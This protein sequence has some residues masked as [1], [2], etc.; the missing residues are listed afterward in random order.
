MKPALAALL[1]FLFLVV[2]TNGAY[3]KIN[4]NSNKY[5]ALVIDAENGEVLYSR[6]AD[7]KRYPASLTKMMTIYLLFEAMR[8]GKITPSQKLNVSSHAAT[9]P[10]TNINLKSGDKIA[11][12]DAIKAL[13]VRSANDVAVVA[14]EAIGGSEWRFAQMMT[15][16][17]HQLGMRSTAFR[18]PHGLPDAQQYTTARDL[19]RLAIAL[20]RDF[21]Q[22]YHYFKTSSFTWKGTTYKSHNRALGRI[23]GADGLKTGY[24]NMSGFN[25]ATSVKRDGYNVVGIVL[26]GQTGRDRDD[27][28]VGLMDKSFIQLAERNGKG[29]KGTQ[30]AQAPIPSPKPDTGV[31]MEDTQEVA[32]IGQG[33]RGEAPETTQKPKEQVVALNYGKVDIV[34][35]DKP[36]L[37]APASELSLISDAKADM[38]QPKT[39]IVEEQIVALD[40][41]PAQPKSTGNIVKAAF[42]PA[43]GTLQ[44]QFAMLQ[45]ENSK[46]HVTKFEQHWGIQVGAFA[47]EK[48]A[49]DAAAKAVDLARDQLKNSKVLVSDPGTKESSIHRARIANL[50]ERQAKQA[51]A[52]LT[53]SSKQC[54]VYRA[55][56]QRDL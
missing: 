22:Y 51:C 6:N 8:D 50:S 14:A 3:A 52:K 33:D 40:D 15:A 38:P 36:S 17:A 12:D 41:K 13:V 29:G 46:S 26:G 34:P 19:S 32:D 39:V 1:S 20:R 23:D 53:A 10:Q 24:I 16:K 2:S 37:T 44:Y 27:H 21:P 28:M 18:N 4:T 49:L 7:S 25:L 48:S 56:M 54:F 30:F 31:T 42:S 47:D 55:D 43:P 35:Q 9:Q 5:A 45:G 11:A